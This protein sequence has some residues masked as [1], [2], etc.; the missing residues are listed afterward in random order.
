M[1]LVYSLVPSSWRRESTK[2]KSLSTDQ[3]P[4]VNKALHWEGDSKFLS[5]AVPPWQHSAGPG[6]ANLPCGGWG[7]KCVQR[8]SGAVQGSVCSLPGAPGPPLW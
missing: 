1:V 7:A 6:A 8:H 5:R 2:L 4:D 3:S